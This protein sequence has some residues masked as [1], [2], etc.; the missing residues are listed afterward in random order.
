MYHMR[1]YFVKSIAA[2]SRDPGA[3]EPRAVYISSRPYF[4]TL[5]ERSRPNIPQYKTSRRGDI[6]ADSK[7]VE[8]DMPI[9]DAR[10]AAKIIFCFW[11]DMNNEVSEL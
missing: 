2:S 11:V 9:S 8:T 5:P 7:R 1:A 6:I 10:P 3:K 4:I